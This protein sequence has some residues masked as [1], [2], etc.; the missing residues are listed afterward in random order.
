MDPS[1][2]GQFNQDNIVVEKLDNLIDLDFQKQENHNGT[3]TQ[4]SSPPT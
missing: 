1:L 4:I 3:T 2:V